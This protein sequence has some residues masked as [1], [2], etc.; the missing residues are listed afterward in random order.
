M[1]NIVREELSHIPKGSGIIHGWLRTY[2]NRRRMHDLSV[3]NITKEETMRWCVN[4]I[5]K[6]TGC[7]PE[8]DIEYFKID[9]ITE[10]NC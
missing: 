7:I 4:E 5:K 6:D 8:Y 9:T 1:S 3:G 10:Q 2:Y